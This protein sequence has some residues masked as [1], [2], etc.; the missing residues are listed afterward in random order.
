MPRWETPSA[1]AAT[2]IR[3]MSVA[4]SSCSSS[5][6]ERNGKTSP[7]PPSREAAGAL[8]FF[9]GFFGSAV[10][11]GVKRDILAAFYFPG[12]N[13]EQEATGGRLRVTSLLDDCLYVH[14]HFVSVPLSCVDHPI[15][16]G[17]IGELVDDELFDDGYNVSRTGLDSCRQ[18]EEPE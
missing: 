9:L 2:S 10:R 17:R 3:L 5:R 8:S 16:A 18:H 13:Q 6:E 4:S 15:V 12:H 1:I 7:A 11:F 14:D